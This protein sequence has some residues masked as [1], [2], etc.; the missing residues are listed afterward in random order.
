MDLNS[1]LVCLRSDYQPSFIQ[2]VCIV[3]ACAN[4]IE[5]RQLASAARLERCL[6]L[7]S[8]IAWRIL[9]ASM[10][11]RALPEAPCTALLEEEEW[12]ALYCAIHNRPTPPRH[13]ADFT[14]RREV[15]RETRWLPGTQQ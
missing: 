4:Y 9:Y 3:D 10:L 7:Y 12:Q 6:T 8:V 15:D 1:L 13:C 11:A 2:Q 5:A 14:Q